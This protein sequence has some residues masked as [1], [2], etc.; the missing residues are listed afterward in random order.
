LEQNHAARPQAGHDARI[1]VSDGAKRF[2]LALAGWLGRIWGFLPAAWRRRWLFG[3]IVLESRSA[4]PAQAL[5]GLFGVADDVQLAINERAMAYGS[6]EHPKHRLTRYHDFFVVRIG[7]A[8]SILDVGCGGGAVARS[9]AR[10][11]PAAR[12]VGIDI[13]ETSI[14]AARG[15]E[16]PPN[17][18]FVCGDATQ[19]LPEGRFEI[20]VLSNV[21]E[22]LDMRVEFMKRMTAATG[23]REILVRVPNFERDWH[24]PMR[25]ELGISHFSDRTHRIEH[26]PDELLAELAAAGLAIVETQLAWGEIWVHCRPMRAAED[27]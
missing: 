10:A 4:A 12:V 14:A 19:A 27:A 1:G 22:H 8:T 24:V 23:A 7:T 6:G 5:R 26:T 11:H 9:I 16:N 25:R 20:V 17:L 3:F 2:G 18:T 21:L 13:E 15:G